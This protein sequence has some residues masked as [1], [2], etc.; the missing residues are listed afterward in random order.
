MTGLP[1]VLVGAGEMFG[2]RKTN[3]KENEGKKMYLE[4]RRDAM[5]GVHICSEG[6]I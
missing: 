6:M 1:L 3:G 5:K 2:A 4:M